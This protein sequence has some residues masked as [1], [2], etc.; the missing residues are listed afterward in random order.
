MSWC[1]K[2]VQKRKETEFSAGTKVP[3][4]KRND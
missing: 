3:T 4:S 1:E 2:I